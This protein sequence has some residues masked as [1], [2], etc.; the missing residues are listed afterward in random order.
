MTLVLNSSFH[1]KLN[2]EFN[3]LLV[4]LMLLISF[5]SFPSEDIL[6]PTSCSIPERVCQGDQC[7]ARCS[8]QWWILRTRP[9]WSVSG[10]WHRELLP[11]PWNTFCTCLQESCLSSVAPSASFSKPPWTLN[12]SMPEGPPHFSVFPPRGWPHL[13]LGLSLLSPYQWLPNFFFRPRPFC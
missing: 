7:H 4:P 1:R 8:I 13:D 11:S 5:L 3:G 9:S 6:V 2:M 10:C 12:A